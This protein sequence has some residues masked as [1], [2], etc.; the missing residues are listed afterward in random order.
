[1]HNDILIQLNVNSERMIDEVTKDKKNYIR[2][3][4]ESIREDLLYAKIINHFEFN[5]RNSNM[6][7]HV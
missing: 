3:H 2:T 5:K 1:M 6:T 4:Y 7:L